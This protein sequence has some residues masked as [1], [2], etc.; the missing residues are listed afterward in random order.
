MQLEKQRARQSKLME[1]IELGYNEEAIRELNILNN[2]I[3]V[4][5]RRINKTFIEHKVITPMRIAVKEHSY[6]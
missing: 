5:Q 2:N 6:Q 1:I 4:T 3:H